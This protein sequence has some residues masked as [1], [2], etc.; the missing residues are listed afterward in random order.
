MSAVFD[1]GILLVNGVLFDSYGEELFSSYES[2]AFWGDFEIS[3]WDCFNRPGSGYPAALPLPL[4]HGY[5]P[6]DVLGEYSTVI[7]LGNNYGGDLGSWQHT[8][9]FR[10]L[11]DGGNVILI[12]CKGQDFIDTNLQNYL[13]ITWNE[14]PLNSTHNC[15]TTFSGLNDMSFSGWQSSNAVF[16]TELTNDESTLLFKETMSFDEER[17]LGVWYH[18]SNGGKYR[19]NGGNFVLSADGLIGLMQMI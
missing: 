18:P 7:W 8:S 12:T 6:S 11:Q 2:R 15:V 17:G 14:K 19:E 9:I 3:F 16:E 5:V 1:Q 10:Y 4:G 13:G